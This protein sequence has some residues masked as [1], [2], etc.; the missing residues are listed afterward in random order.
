MERI[1]CGIDFGT[2]NS[3]VAVAMDQ[4]IIL[5]P[6][7]ETHVT[8]PSALFFPPQL[9]PVFG[10]K[11]T[12]FF[13]ERRE[14]RFMRSLKRVLGNP[15]MKQGTLV[16]GRAVKFEKIIGDFLKNLRAT[17]NAFTRHEVENVVMG[18]PV[19]FV[20]NNAAADSTAQE[21]LRSI[22]RAVG[23]KN[24]EFQLEPIA[25]AFAHE[26][27]IKKEQV[28]I[29][30]DLGGGTSDFT[31]IKV[32]QDYMAKADR[33]SDV[34]ASTG[35]RIGGNDFDKN[36][37]L[38]IIM[39]E[40]GYKSTYGKKNLE[41]P[42]IYYH[43]MAEWSKVNFLYTAKVR[44]KVQQLYNESHDQRR[45]GRLLKILDQENGHSVLAA[46]EESKIALTSTSTIKTDM[47]F[48]EPDFFI[49]TERE[50]F[51]NA[52][53]SDMQKILASAN[54]CLTQAQLKSADIQLVILTG[55]S[56]EVPKV[57]EAFRQLFPV[58]KIADENK[59]SSV[60]LGLAYDSERRFR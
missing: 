53:E 14:G 18:R 24:V 31:I 27:N 15:A 20:D 55:G 5:V 47:S 32:S 12:Q 33:T 59:L 56:T 35:V 52:I 28:A 30:V 26:K 39:P 58:A 25:A 13:F 10:R 6:L 8:I 2:S 40:L 48:L 34:L 1:S 9:P 37:C 42:M 60:G 54:E 38:S 17:T 44:T 23:F 43:D 50:T 49:T 11:A 7:E 29:V 4:N 19:H 22:A 21:E 16:N 51:E 46:T 3:S 57:K 36:L 41:V 45:F